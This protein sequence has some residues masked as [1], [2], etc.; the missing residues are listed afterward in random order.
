MVVTDLFV[1]KICVTIYKT[2]VYLVKVASPLSLSLAK[3]RAALLFPNDNIAFCPA[4]NIKKKN[5]RSQIS[6]AKIRYCKV[7]ISGRQTT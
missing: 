5:K 6:R 4:L 7:T 3:H 2:S 1:R